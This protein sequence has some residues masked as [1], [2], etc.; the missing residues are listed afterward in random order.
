MQK[1]FIRVSHHFYL[2]NFHLRGS[3]LCLKAVSSFSDKFLL[4]FTDFLKLTLENYV[5]NLEVPVKIIRMEERSGLIRARLR[6]AAASK[7]QVITFLDA[8]CEC[9]L[10]WLEPLLARIKED[11]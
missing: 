7:G 9:T 2:L 11:R 4:H 5:K 8:H 1:V 10:G 6:G 3:L